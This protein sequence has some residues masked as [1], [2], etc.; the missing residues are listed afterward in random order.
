MDE[1]AVVAV[2]GEKGEDALC[3][4]R[5]Q[6]RKPCALRLSMWLGKTPEAVRATAGFGCGFGG[7]WPSFCE[8]VDPVHGESQRCGDVQW[9]CVLVGEQD[10]AAVV[11]GLEDLPDSG[12]E[13]G[14]APSL[15]DVDGDD[16]VAA[17]C[18]GARRLR[19]E[20]F[21][22]VVVGVQRVFHVVY[23]LY[24]L[25][26]GC[27]FGADVVGLVVEADFGCGHDEF[28]VDGGVAD[29][30]GP[31]TSFGAAQDGLVEV[32]L[33]SDESCCGQRRVVVCVGH[34]AV[35]ERVVDGQHG[36]RGF[37]VGVG[38]CFDFQQ[39]VGASRVFDGDEGARASA[40]IAELQGGRD[41]FGRFGRGHD[42]V[43]GAGVS[44]DDSGC[45]R[46]KMVGHC[47]QFVA[48]RGAVVQVLHAEHVG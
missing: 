27:F 39:R 37:G 14:L 5:Q 47:A 44:C 26:V 17:E 4:D 36:V 42:V 24:A 18:F 8:R 28:V 30:Y 16:G 29:G 13:V 41:A 2:G 7:G 35:A 3:R 25:N 48:C 34:V 19:R 31:H 43:V 10:G 40:G 32:D 45:A 9:F 38:G 21:Y 6:L 33:V 1:E 11:L 23:G 46:D 22:G 15:W 12:V 20:V